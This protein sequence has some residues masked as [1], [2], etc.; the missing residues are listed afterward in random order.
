MKLLRRV[1]LLWKVLLPPMMAMLCMVIYLGAS[2]YV[3]KQNNQRLANMRDVQFPVLDTSTEN[4]GA[5]DKIIDNLNGAAASGEQEQLRV[6]AA[7]ADK[8]RA[9]YARLRTIDRGEAEA[10]QRLAAEFD[11]YYSSAHVL[12]KQLV[13]QNGV[14]DQA[15]VKTM[16][17]Q[18][19]TYRKD[20]TAF[21]DAAKRR[22]AD[23]IG[24]ATHDADSAITSGAALGILGLVA[25][26]GFGLV[27]ARALLLQL[28]HAVGVAQT[29]AAG[30]LSSDIDVSSGD[31]AG[32]LAQSL[33][34]MNASLAL[35]VG[36]VRGGTDLIATASS[37][38]AAGNHKL[39]SRTE[40]QAGSLEETASSMEELST[41]VKQNADNAHQANQLALSASEVASRGGAVVT[42]VVDTMGAINDSARKIV[43]IIGVIEGI[44]FQTNILALNAAVEAARAG[45]QGRGFA[46]VASEVRNL[47][48]RSAAAAKEIKTLIGNSVS[49]VDLGARLVEQAGRTMEEI[50]SSVERVTNIMGEIT[51]ASREQIS[52]IEQ[53]HQAI[54][55]MDQAT[56]QN[57]ALVEETA[58]A[59]ESLQ[60]QADN[61]ARVVSVFKLPSAHPAPAVSAAAWSQAE[62]T[63]VVPAQA[64]RRD[65]SLKL[66]A[67]GAEEWERL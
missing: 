6:A 52:G 47:A 43:D 63:P 2:S 62:R 30:D 42:Q 12:A 29:V 3:L 21:R 65:A 27:V 24:S 66:V 61:L 33:R 32:Q 11:A 51:T 67:G 15:A 60:E 26:L 1:P 45:E 48:Q 38:I 44:A 46:V 20:L 22:F 36:E 57:S 58:A 53:V 7:I 14:P 19:D 4:V 8:V 16:S 39:S 56:Q 59:A 55:R 54:A 49:Q 41:T 17:R 50:V 35:I 23:T 25:T 34:D 9:N 10:L 18:L 40:E 64:A 5:L 13:D 28:T 31:E 37:Q